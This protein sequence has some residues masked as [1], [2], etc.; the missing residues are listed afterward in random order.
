MTNVLRLWA[1]AVVFAF[2]AAIGNA[3]DAAAPAPTGITGTSLT[4]LMVENQKAIE[5]DVAAK[6]GVA[7]RAPGQNPITYYYTIYNVTGGGPILSWLKV[8]VSKFTNNSAFKA[9]YWTIILVGGAICS[10]QALYSTKSGGTEYLD[11]LAGFILK[12]GVGTLIVANPAFIYAMTMT[13]RDGF[14]YTV[15]QIIQNSPSA[16]KAVQDVIGTHSLSSQQ[17]DASKSKAIESAIQDRMA[18]FLDPKTTNLERKEMGRAMNA[19]A[20]AVN[21]AKG[22]PVISIVSEDDMS[23]P[24]ASSHRQLM[25][26]QLR[27]S[28]Q[29]LAGLGTKEAS[30][31]TIEYPSGNQMPFALLGWA[32]H[33][34]DKAPAKTRQKIESMVSTP[35]N[36]IVQQQRAEQYQKEVYVTSRNNIDLVI[37]GVMSKSPIKGWTEGFS[38]TLKSAIEYAAAGPSEMVEKTMRF[39][40]N[41]VNQMLA[42]VITP[43]VTILL[44]L[45]IEMNVWLMVVVMPLWL[46]PVTP[47]AFPAVF[48]SLFNATIFLPVFQLLMLITDAIFAKVLQWASTGGF[49][50]VAVTPVLGPLPALGIGLGYIVAYIVT[51]IVLLKKTPA[52]INAAFSGAGA[53]G[54]FVGTQ[55]KG[56]AAGVLAAGGIVAAPAVTGAAAAAGGK[57]AAA[58]PSLAKGMAARLPSGLRNA[59]RTISYKAR[60]AVASLPAP[61]RR[62]GASFRAGSSP[63][64]GPARA[65]SAAPAVSATSPASAAPAAS[66][67]STPGGPAQSGAQ[68]APPH[69]SITSPYAYALGR[70]SKAIMDGIRD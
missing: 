17:L 61:I 54:T 26:M 20:A 48:R 38:E 69:A 8:P 66:R 22:A 24:N 16:A 36:L 19:V 57:L 47:K 41:G 2:S 7:P 51:V 67:P 21:K 42:A 34:T 37:G 40:V 11:R 65:A 18:L 45:L 49:V 31:F 33:N 43:A 23:S 68:P 25:T 14:N 27:Q 35:D 3:Q 58:A 6:A 5:A 29:T 12:L 60:S 9:L 63:A 1:I 10:L 62:V 32:L 30:Q 13:L 15:A 52:I 55:A 4:A 53:V 59:G 46:L 39:V 28:F 50:T 56:L 70:T 44:N 64:T